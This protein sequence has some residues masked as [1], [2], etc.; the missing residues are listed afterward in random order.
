MTLK[1]YILKLKD[2]AK[3]NPKA[4]ELEVIHSSDDE[5]NHFTPVVFDPGTLMKKE[6]GWDY[7]NAEIDNADSVCIN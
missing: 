1:E 3:N 2:F 7:I 4:L 5:G 6:T